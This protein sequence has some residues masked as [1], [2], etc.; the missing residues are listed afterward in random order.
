MTEI[1]LHFI[2]IVEASL[3]SNAKSS[4][5]IELLKLMQLEVERSG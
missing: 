5:L 4:A 2:D 3:D 1:E